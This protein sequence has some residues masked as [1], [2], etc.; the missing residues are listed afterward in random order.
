VR[1]TPDRARG[2][3]SDL[4]AR[5]IAIAYST[6]QRRRASRRQINEER[7]MINF[8]LWLIVGGVVGWLASLIMRTDAQQ[9]LVLNIVVGIIGAAIAGWVLSPL[10]GVP[11]INEQFSIAS[12]LVSL[13][14]A[15]ILL[16]IVNLFRRGRVR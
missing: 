15:V 4:S 1:A 12:V 11:S 2:I 5:G 9:G 6:A 10:V 8:I 7:N 3:K 16:A 14:G 13:V